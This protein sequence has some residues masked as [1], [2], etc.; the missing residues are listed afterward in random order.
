MLPFIFRIL[1]YAEKIAIPKPVSRATLRSCLAC[2]RNQIA[3]RQNNKCNNNLCIA[4][5]RAGT[6][7]KG[8]TKITRR[9]SSFDVSTIIAGIAQ[10]V[11]K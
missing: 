6:S 10:A 9:S 7:R 3:A 8:V 4:G 2:S 5:S 11:Q 1:L